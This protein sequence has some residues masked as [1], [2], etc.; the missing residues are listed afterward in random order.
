M[1]FYSG[2][3]KLPAEAQVFGSSLFGMAGSDPRG[4]QGSTTTFPWDS[5]SIQDNREEEEE[6]GKPQHSL[7]EGDEV[8]LVLV[9][10]LSVRNVGDVHHCGDTWEG[11]EAA[12]WPVFCRFT[13]RLP[14]QV[15]KCSLSPS[16]R[17]FCS[18]C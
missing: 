10:R 3:T 12:F 7:L 8:L 6:E 1:F 13:R 14:A 9:V 4:N 5:G 11:S 2:G 16:L 18:I 17:R 15:G